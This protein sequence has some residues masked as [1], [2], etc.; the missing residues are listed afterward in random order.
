[1]RDFMDRWVGYL[2]YLGSPTSMTGPKYATPSPLYLEAKAHSMNSRPKDKNN[3]NKLYKSL[4]FEFIA[5][6]WLD[7]DLK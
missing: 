5:L 4:V 3:R 6:Q 7:I 1:M 2:T